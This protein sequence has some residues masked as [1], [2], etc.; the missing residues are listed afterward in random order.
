[1][2]QV[3]KLLFSMKLQNL[4]Y[5]KERGVMNKILVF[6]IISKQDMNWINAELLSC[7]IIKLHL[8]QAPKL[9]L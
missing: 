3:L 1:M 6:Y 7:K 9:L 8:L 4:M 5:Q 2:V